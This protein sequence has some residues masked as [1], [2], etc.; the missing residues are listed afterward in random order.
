MPLGTALLAPTRIYADA[1]KAA[2]LTGT[3]TSISH[4]TGGGLIENPPRV[5]S[6]ELAL[7]LELKARPLPPVFYWLKQAAQIEN[8]ELARTF[9]CG[10]G[11]LIS[12]RPE[13]ADNIL[14]QIL[15][16]GED[17]WIAGSIVKRQNHA[18]ILGHVESAWA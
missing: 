11:M 18:V 12:V 6:D 4:I 2:L 16:T 1:V 14:N 13:D 3:V 9:N 5:F 17:C 10:I 7:H 8:Y 15:H